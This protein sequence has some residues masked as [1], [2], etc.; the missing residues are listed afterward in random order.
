MAQTQIDDNEQRNTMT[1][2]PIVV[3]SDV[4]KRWYIILFVVVLAAASAY[5][6]YDR[7]YKPQYTTDTTFVISSQG[8]STTVYQNLNAASSLASVFSELIN[9]SILREKILGSLGMRSFSGRITSSVIPETN[10]LTMHV[11]ASD[12]RT[13]FLVTEAILENHSV[14]TERVMGDI[15][16][17]V[18][19]KPEVPTKPSNPKNVF[20]QTR[21]IALYAF[22]GICGILA[23]MSYASDRVRSRREAEKKLNCTV[24]GT[25]SYER[26]KRTLR[27]VLNN[28]KTGLLVTKPGTSFT[29]IEEMRK[30]RHRTEQHMSDDAKVILITSV[31][32][33]EGKSTV[34]VNLAITMAQK[35]QRVLLIDADMKKPACRKILEIPEVPHSLS[36]VIKGKSSLKEA[37]I[38][39]PQQKQL[40]LL[41]QGRSVRGSDR[42]I[43]SG[44]MQQLFD[45]VRDMFDVIIVDTSPLSVSADSNSIAEYCDASILVVRQNTAAASWIRKGI[46]SI[47]TGR[48]RFLGIILNAVHRSGLSDQGAYGYGSYGRYGKYGHYGKYG[49]YGYG[50]YDKYYGHYAQSEPSG[51]GNTTEQETNV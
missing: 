26:K 33:N 5:I 4:L 30:V 31:L 41:L 29:F 50:R 43:A 38:Q 2:D 28:K 36:D 9:S 48:I 6:Y 12:P 16:F 44:T 14:V 25:L 45:S 21:K 3:I 40:Y 46:D 39:Y 1:V 23:V 37:M 10:L 42:M 34:A 19:Q 51:N 22:L 35:Q 18:L 8:N 24:L 49:K 20:G 17:E 47:N 13:A 11:T 15:A 7:S 27:D 32:E